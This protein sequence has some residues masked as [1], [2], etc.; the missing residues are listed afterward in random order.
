MSITFEDSKTQN[1]NKVEFQNFNN[2]RRSSATNSS[3]AQN[4]GEEY[5]QAYAGLAQ[6]QRY[7][8][9]V[10]RA[11]HDQKTK[12]DIVNHLRHMFYNKDQGQSISDFMS[13]LNAFHR[14]NVVSSPNLHQKYF[15][16]VMDKAVQNYGA[17]PF[18]VPNSN[19]TISFEEIVNQGLQDQFS[20]DPYFHQI[21]DLAMQ[22]ILAE[23]SAESKQLQELYNQLPEESKHFDKFGAP[24]ARGVFSMTIASQIG[25]HGKTKVWDHFSGKNAFKQSVAAEINDDF[26]GKLIDKKAK[27][28]FINEKVSKLKPNDPLIRR[29]GYE[30]KAWDKLTSTQKKEILKRHFSGK[31]YVQELA[32]YTAKYAKEL[33]GEAKAEFFK[34]VR[35][36]A[37]SSSLNSLDDIANNRHTQKLKGLSGTKG[38]R[39]AKYVDEVAEASLKSVR[40]ARVATAAG[41]VGRLSRAGNFMK[42]IFKWGPKVL[43]LG[44]LAGGPIGLVASLAAGFVLDMAINEG[45]NFFSNISSGKD[46]KFED[47]GTWNPLTWGVG[48]FRL[49]NAGEGLAL[50][51]RGGWNW[52]STGS[53]TVGGNI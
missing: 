22:D 44:G 50:G 8:N 38:A 47:K 25:Y 49:S 32:E 5:R 15:S 40:K 21:L 51:L 43:R 12:L 27:K 30:S 41:K 19:I 7:L 17:S 52:L 34:I 46:I 28:S 1:S 31:K 45:M 48:K 9:Q 29:L 16:L 36:S 39:A 11:Y 26:V 18:Q 24:V 13:E 20:N 42:N 14:E 23:D 35:R 53:F 6:E 2:R 10:E 3:F 33:T 37:P 4:N